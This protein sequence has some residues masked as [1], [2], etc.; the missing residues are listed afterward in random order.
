MMSD[1]NVPAPHSADAVAKHVM[2]RSLNH[3]FTLIPAALGLVGAVGGVVFEMHYVFLGGALGVLFGAAHFVFS[4][5]MRRD[6][7]AQAYFRQLQDAKLA[8]IQNRPDHLA[9]RM[10]SA[11]FQRG[12]EQLRAAESKF[13]AFFT[14]LN[15]RFEKNEITYSRYA[16]VA[17]TVFVSVLDNLDLVMSKMGSVAAIDPHY[18]NAR[19]GELRRLD[20]QSEDLKPLEERL[21]LRSETLDGVERL[22][23][24]NEHAITSLTKASVGVASIQTTKTGHVRDAGLAMEDLERLA[25]RATDY[26]RK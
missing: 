23:V 17:E 8:Q 16:S 11:G 15:A 13:E 4:F 24:E 10:T 2:S 1:S 25:A 7:H 18:L 5:F 9:D 6:K 26:E 12:V 14:A 21:D 20:P 3:P 19:I 22:L